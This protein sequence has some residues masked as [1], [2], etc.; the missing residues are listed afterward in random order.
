VIP[1]ILVLIMFYVGWKNFVS[2]RTAPDNTM[3]VSV[4]ARMWSWQ[5]EYENG[6]KSSILRVPLDKAVTL[7]LTSE[8]VIHSLFVPDFKIK[9]D[10]VP[11]MATSLW[12]ITDKTGEY[13][14]FCAEYC[15]QGH[16]AMTSKVVVMSAD[17]FNQW[18]ETGNEE[19]AAL[20]EPA[21]IAEL[22]EDNGCLD[23][24]STDGSRMVGPSF[25]GIYGRPTIVVVDGKERNIIADDAY[26]KKAILYPDADIVKGYPEVM[27]SFEGE[28]SDE[29]VSLIVRYLKELK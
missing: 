1:T 10:A 24:H 16:S 17:S 2:L 18:Y 11:G 6:L 25:K 5:F 27:P 9:E 12:F 8:D 4:T 22:L 15:G 23:C 19:K 26:L 14:I 7:S 3:H 20:S 28:L 13:D 21:R 29:G